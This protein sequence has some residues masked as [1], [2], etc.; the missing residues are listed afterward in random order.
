MKFAIALTAAALV[1]LSASN[2]FAVSASVKRAC[3][4][5]YLSY[6]SQHSP[7]SPGVRTCFRS[8]ASKISNRCVKALVKAG[9]V[10]SKRAR[11]A[12]IR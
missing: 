1:S 11:A 4:G 9:Y 2:A 7:S 12:G 3:I 8:N 5:D 10:S 6:C